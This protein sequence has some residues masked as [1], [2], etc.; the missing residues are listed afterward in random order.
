MLGL[1]D[2]Q[3]KFAVHLSVIT[4][5]CVEQ[6]LRDWMDEAKGKVRAGRKQRTD[7]YAALTEQETAWKEHKKFHRGTERRGCSCIVWDA[8][9]AI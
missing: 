3:W 4:R 6:K 7:I 9:N 5:N 8:W 1:N 2:S